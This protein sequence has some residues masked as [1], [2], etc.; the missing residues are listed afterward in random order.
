MHEVGREHDTVYIVT[1]YVEGA[2]LREWLSGQRLSF[3]E[4]AEMIVKVA[5]AI[6]HAHQ[7]GVVHRDV[8]PG[9]I[10][11]D[12]D[13]EPHVIDFGMARRETGEI[14]ITVD[15]H[16]LGTPAYMSPEQASGKGH[17]A[18]RRSDVYSLG[19]ILFELL[20]G[21]LPFRGETQM[22]LMQIQRD[23]P[24]RPRRLN[25]RIPRDLETI[26]LKCLQKEPARRYQ[27][28]R[29]LADDLKRWHSGKPIVARPVGRIERGWRWVRRNPVVA[30]LLAGIVVSSLTG[31]IVSA[32]F[33]IQAEL[34]AEDAIAQKARADAKASEAE[35]N[36]VRATD[37]SSKANEEAQR[38]IIEA[39]KAQQ[40]AR[41]LARMFEESAPYHMGGLRFGVTEKALARGNLTARE[42]LD[43][44]A[45]RVTAELQ[46]Q[47]VVQAA[48]MDT[49]GNVYLGMGMIEKAEVLL[50]EAFEL[51]QKHL[52][53]E[54]PDMANS[55]HSIGV[56]RLAQ[57]RFLESASAG[58]EAL[59]IRRKLL[60]DDHE[61]VDDTR[62]ALA[63]VLGLFLPE[64]LEGAQ[65]AVRLWRE[66]LAWRRRHLGNAHR[67]TAVAM[68]GLAGALLN[69]S[70]N[71]NEAPRLVLEATPIL[72]KDPTTNSLGMA[73][74][75]LVQAQIML[76][77]NRRDAVV[78]ATRKAIAAA[79]DAMDDDHI[80]MQVVKAIA[81]TNLAFASQFDEA[82]KLY[83]ECVATLRKHNVPPSLWL[84]SV[85]Q[86][87][88]VQLQREDPLRAE[89][90]Y[91]EA[92]EITKESIVRQRDSKDESQIDNRA[93]TAAVFAYGS[94]LR[95]T[96]RTEEVEA[97]YREYPA[98][99][100]RVQRPKMRDPVD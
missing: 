5:E 37:A 91:R 79:G 26:T 73:I 85:M 48:L 15:G 33:A 82:E 21:E 89:A 69:G 72:L 1:D 19:V 66:T 88:A 93:F 31:A 47:P 2:N 99:R 17:D 60:G 87:I 13:L 98:V 3:R 24:P 100:P 7:S 65:E 74:S 42:I 22:L 63:T 20:T 43:R 36:A 8:K 32:Y 76:G 10:M 97:L 18:D 41:F 78:A 67:E 28:A 75:Q 27:T 9:N 25:A 81:A 68:V 46:D 84:I 23:E 86:S 16:I 54:H 59:A 95:R 57:F 58:K 62:M 14:T 77:L 92:I 51:R 96:G 44:G 29:Q 30:G 61:L 12:R 38:A 34:R 56:L 6:H 80:F 70:D 83:R 39:E 35:T 94:M 11:L 71:A 53:R 40:V 55:W 49:I 64:G 4:V 52:P 90:L 45:Q 50:Q